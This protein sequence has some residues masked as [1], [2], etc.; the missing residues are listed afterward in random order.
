[1]FV[2]FQTHKYQDGFLVHKQWKYWKLE[3]TLRDNL[4]YD[5]LITANNPNYLPA[6]L[7]KVDS[8]AFSA[9]LQ[10]PSFVH[11]EREKNNTQVVAS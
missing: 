7:S 9:C 10:R 3:L 2:W 5:F 11:R 1:M 8:L 6:C 4:C